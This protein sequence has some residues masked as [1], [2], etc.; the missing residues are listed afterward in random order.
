VIDEDAVL[1]L[2]GANRN[3]EE[4]R[5]GEWKGE[6]QKRSDGASRPHRDSELE[7]PIMAEDGKG[8]LQ[9]GGQIRGEEGREERECGAA[10]PRRY[11]RFLTAEIT[12]FGEGFLSDGGISG[13]V[14]R[15]RW[16]RR[17]WA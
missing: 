8:F 5:A 12:N 17:V 13:A 6:G 2:P 11:R 7:L 4:V 15:G 1:G 16:E 10:S 9:P 14:S 3:D